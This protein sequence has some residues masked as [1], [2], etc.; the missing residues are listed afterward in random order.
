MLLFTWGPAPVTYQVR[1]RMSG[2]VHNPNSYECGDKLSTALKAD[3]QPP[4][5]SGKM[6]TG[7]LFPDKIHH[8]KILSMAEC[9][10]IQLSLKERW[11]HSVAM[12]SNLCIA[13]LHQWR[14]VY[15]GTAFPHRAAKID[16][17]LQSSLIFGIISGSMSF[18]FCCSASSLCS[19]EALDS[20]KL[21]R[22]EGR[23]MCRS[24][25]Q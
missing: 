14:D 9:N 2:T 17:V 22:N 3:T 18:V 21:A 16:R 10:I 20:L 4:S 24:L 8:C 12:K 13:T 5:P 19:W 11:S 23:W 15:T 1:S 7:R 25:K 6:W